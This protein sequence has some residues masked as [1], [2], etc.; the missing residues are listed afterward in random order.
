MQGGDLVSMFE[1]AY[2]SMLKNAHTGYATKSTLDLIRHLYLHCCRISAT[3]MS[4]NEENLCF[5]Y[6]ME[7]PLQGV[8]K[9]LSECTNFIVAEV[10][11]VT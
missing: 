9:I 7:D 10:E 1:D 6:N 5:L 8:I 4:V 3:Y 11:P 2:L